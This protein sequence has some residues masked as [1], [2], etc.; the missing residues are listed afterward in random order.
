LGVVVALSDTS[1]GGGSA[2]FH[3]GIKSELGDYRSSLLR[4]AN[5]G[6]KAGITTGG[7]LFIGNPP[8]KAGDESGHLKE[9]VRLRLLLQPEGELYSVKFSAATLDGKGISTVA[10]RARADQLDGNIALVNN[11]GPARQPRRKRGQPA[12]PRLPTRALFTFT[13]WKLSGTK[14][15][16][17]ED[18]AWGPILYAMHSLSRNVMKMTAQMPPVGA[19]EEQQVKLQTRN[20]E[21]W[22]ETAKADIDA[23]SRT[24]TFKI[25][26]WDST[27]DTPY[28]LVYTMVTRGGA[29]TDHAFE[30]TVR[31]DPVEK[32]KVVVAG[33]T[34]NT[35]PAF[36][37]EHL[38]RNVAIHDPD[39]L[40]FTGDQ[41]YEGVG[42][43]GIH[44]S[45]VDVAVLN[46]LRKVYLW[47][48]AFRDVMR[49]RVT[50][51]LADDHDVYQGNIWGQGGRGVA[52]MRDHAKGGYAMHP[53]FVNAVQRTLS[54]HHPDPFDATPVEQGIGVYYG[55]MVYGRISF[56]VIEDRKFKSGPNGKVNTWKGRPDHIRDPKF[57]PKSIDKPGLVL[58][59]DRQLRFLK[60]WSADWR[61]A[62]MKVVCSQTI[63]CNLA[64]YHGGGQTFIVADLDSNGW[65]QT[66]RNKA[67]LEMRKGFAF[68][69]AGDQ[70]LASIVHHGVDT[71]NDAGYSFCVPSIAAG[72][73]RAW[74]PDKE[75]RKAQNRPPG[76]LPNT[77]EYLDGLRNRVTVY[78]VGNPEKVKRRPVLELLHDKASG[79]GLVRFDKKNR[80]IEIECWRLLIDASEPK[81][82]DQF[83][84]WPKTIDMQ[85]NYGR[86]PAAWLPTIEV[87]GMK[88]PVIQIINEADGEIVYTLRIK[89]ASFRPKVFKAGK[90]TVKVGDQDN[91]NM[92]TFKGVSSH[93]SGQTGKL[94]VKF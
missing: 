34:G 64:N 28:R 2:G 85:D 18:H 89:G 77:G 7:A 33:F 31:K 81:P 65:P 76:N 67:L 46:Y 15:V 78:A 13:D 79:Y 1:K 71:W 72:Y 53:D 49:D 25:T 56:A 83:P 43:F 8:S 90:Y 23:L 59:G 45:P 22:N 38:A 4:G 66:G 5:R 61:G 62:D 37:N 70:H 36:P 94:Q 17:H 30:G 32:E 11:F 12:P 73:P 42:G 14:L 39:V 10:G 68:H 27:R 3:L 48:W 41:I 9:G 35:D 29:K 92:K 82:G 19:K 74:R 60:H 16:A 91:N 93:E 40:L 69:Y 52:S 58:L 51:A 63:F 86:A 44:R 47:G 80:K 50:L 54:S 21:E 24:A 84:G 26:N 55:D 57:D 20:G 6:I 75:G 87:Q 88:D